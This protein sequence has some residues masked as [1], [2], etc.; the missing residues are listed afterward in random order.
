MITRICKAAAQACSRSS[1][2][3]ASTRPA[4]D[5]LTGS[6]CASTPAVAAPGEHAGPFDPQAARI[7][8]GT[9]VR[10]F[11]MQ[12]NPVGRDAATPREMRGTITFDH[13][14]VGLICTKN[15]LND[16][17][18]LF[19]TKPSWR[20]GAGGGIESGDTVTLS[21]DR[22]TLTVHLTVGPAHDQLRVLVEAPLSTNVIAS[23]S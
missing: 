19:A 10:S 4:C 9:R 15:E 6:S 13:P 18:G 3:T 5:N 7:A 20:P 14:I 8:G 12:F 16:V 23:R 2:I 17:D 22:R 1:A 21:E 11:L